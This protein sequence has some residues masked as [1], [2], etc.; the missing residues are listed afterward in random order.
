MFHRLI[1]RVILMFLV[2][3]TL[4]ALVACTAAPV[5]PTSVPT[6]L[7]TPTPMVAS[8][9]PSVTQGTQLLTNEESGY[10]LLY[11]DG[12]TPVDPLPGEVCFVPGDTS[13]ECHSANLIIE[14]ENANGRTPSQIADELI[15][16]AETAGPGIEIQR[17]D[18]TVSGEQAVMLE[19]VPGVDAS[20][21]VVLVHADRLYRLMF[22]PWDETREEFTGVENLY[23]TAIDSFTFLR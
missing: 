9:C 1:G 7:P 22:V 8:D 13:M 10:C 20:R 11:P 17:T 3:G 14:M 6:L 15:A 2:L 23:N 12:Y 21:I 5:T 19:G 18:L 4:L 16:E